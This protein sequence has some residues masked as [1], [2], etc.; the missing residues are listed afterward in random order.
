MDKLMPRQRKEKSKQLDP[1]PSYQ[2]TYRIGWTS[3]FAELVHVCG[4]DPGAG[5]G[6][7]Q[8]DQVNEGLV[9]RGMMSMP[10]LVP[11]RGFVRLFNYR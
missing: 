4:H 1:D 3:C 7:Q 8:L 9:D 2:R 10:F 6:W 5:A 11:L